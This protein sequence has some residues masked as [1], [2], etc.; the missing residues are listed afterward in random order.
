MEYN[1]TVKSNK[2]STRNLILEKISLPK[3]NYIDFNLP[4]N[5]KS[6]IHYWL[7]EDKQK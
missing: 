1:D 6:I 3:I 2:C 4:F 5:L 7:S